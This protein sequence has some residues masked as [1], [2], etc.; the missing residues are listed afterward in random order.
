MNNPERF[1]ISLGLIVIL[2]FNIQSQPVSKERTM[3]AME[4]ANRYFM[5]KWP[6]VGKTIITE[7]ERPSNIWT[8]GTYYEGLMALYKLKPDPEYLK[9]AV[10]W[11]EF[12]KWGL[13]NG[14]KTRN[15]DDQCC[16]QTYIDLYLMDRSKD[17]RIRD[18]K[19]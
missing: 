15:G 7:R 14:V 8:R 3:A 6:D 2:S 9:Y 1:F 11:G 16:G 4:L 17:E 13:R 18:I 5:E 12:H 10:N 19:T